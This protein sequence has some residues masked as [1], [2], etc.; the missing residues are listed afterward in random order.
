MKKTRFTALLLAALVLVSVPALSQ[1]SFTARYGSDQA[2]AG[3][4]PFAPKFSKRTVAA[5]GDGSLADVIDSVVFDLDA[6]Q[7]ASY[8]GSGTTW[9]NLV[10]APAD[11][12][13]QTAYDF[14]TGDGATST[15]YPA[16]NGS[17]GS[18]A[19]YWSFDGGDYFGIKS[20]ANTAFLNS[21]QKTTGGTDWWISLAINKTDASWTTAALFATLGAVPNYNGI[22]IDTVS[23]E[24]FQLNQG[25][26][27]SGI[28]PVFSPGVQTS[29]NYIL[30]ISYSTTGNL[31]MW[32][33]SGT[34]VLEQAIAFSTNVVDAQYPARI[35]SRGD[36]SLFINAETRIYSVAG[37]NEYLD[38]T[39]AAAI[40]AALE[41]RH[42]RDYTP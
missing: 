14:Y 7:S 30:I 18:S 1:P 6:T 20:G 15:T 24:D 19:A 39:K 28:S 42:G 32:L 5:S 22:S 12:S 29:G 2:G 16:F 31:R 41:A 11:G 21:L 33:N 10:T 8:S 17:A 3:W 40:I 37:G 13:A 25:N 9:A 23:T 35:G 36:G 4:T 38:D 34:A 26:G 27:S